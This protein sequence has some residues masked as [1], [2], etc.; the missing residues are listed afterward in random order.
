MV[1]PR[2]FGCLLA[3]PPWTYVTWSPGEGKRASDH[4]QTQD[5]DWIC[6]LPVSDIAAKDSTLLL[7]ATIPNLPEAF[8]VIEAWEFRYKSAIPWL[9]MSRAGC[10]R[11]GIGYHAR[12]CMEVLLIANRGEAR[13]PETNR[14]PLGVIVEPEE[15]MPVIFNPIGAHSRKPSAQYEIAEGYSGPHV[16]IFARPRPDGLF[17]WQRPGWVH[18]GNEVDGLDMREALLRLATSASSLS[19]LP[20]EGKGN[21]E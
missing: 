21:G 19:S 15:V 10:P 7:W 16:E 1:A 3:D 9:K 11:M 13:A 2:L 4:Y 17:P 8:R 12:S 18:L 20:A 5:I 6:S 14:R